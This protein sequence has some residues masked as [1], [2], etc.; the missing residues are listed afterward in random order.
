[1]LARNALKPIE[2]KL[3]GVHMMNEE[4]LESIN[5]YSSPG[6]HSRSANLVSSF[7][8]ERELC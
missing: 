5:E 4:R 8:F 7:T 2:K 6:C 1:M 3:N